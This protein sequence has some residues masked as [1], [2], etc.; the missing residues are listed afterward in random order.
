MVSKW[1]WPGN[2]TFIEVASMVVT[3]W[4]VAFLCS[5]L[6][7]C[8]VQSWQTMLSKVLWFY[9]NKSTTTNIYFSFPRDQGTDSMNVDTCSYVQLYI[10]ILANVVFL[11]RYLVAFL[12]WYSLYFWGVVCLGDFFSWYNNF[13]ILFTY[14]LTFY[15]ISLKSVLIHHHN[16]GGSHGIW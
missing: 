9:G 11:G 1:L 6:V 5:V 8:S 4:T 13:L 10:M 14:I 7:F 2:R 12:S 3:W 16:P 15:S